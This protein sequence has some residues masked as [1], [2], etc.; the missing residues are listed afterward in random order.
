MEKAAKWGAA[1]VGGTTA[2]VGA[3]T[4]L[5]TKTAGT[6]DEIDKASQRVGIT[7]EEY[8]K[9]AY[10]ADMSGVSTSTLEGAAKKL[11][12]TMPEADL[13]SVIQDLAGIT[14]ESER[15]AKAQELLG[16]SAAYELTPLL[17]AGADGIT[18]LKQE[19][20][21]LG[22][23]M[24][25]DTVAAGAKL[26]DTISSIK[27]SFSGMVASLGSAVMPIVQKF[28]EMIK[29]HLPDI[30][31]MVEKLAPVIMGLLENLLPPLFS[32]AETLLPVIIDLFSN[33]LPPLTQ[34]AEAILPVIVD[35]LGMILPPLMQIVSAVLPLLLNLLKPLL[36]LLKPLIDLLQPILDLV[37]TILQ[38]IITLINTLLPPLIELLSG[39]L[40]G[41]L[42]L[43]SEALG[44]VATVIGTVF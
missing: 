22:M 44:T 43:L 14:D 26:G 17:N 4:S 11:A 40:G 21:D 8:Q 5:A 33:I 27:Q 12:K 36:D 3:V 2:A 23:V 9:L 10:A 39:I 34:I 15:A 28:A 41:V 32:L 19:C 38:P 30:Q 18:A 16:R 13:S 20:E 25:N 42:P 7:A 6:A 1:I 37:T 31:K 35:V 24:S 29:S